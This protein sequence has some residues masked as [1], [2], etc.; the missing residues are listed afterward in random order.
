MSAAVP[1][2]RRRYD[3]ALIQ[4]CFA[5]PRSPLLFLA[6]ICMHNNCFVTYNHISRSRAL[7][8]M[9]PSQRHYVLIIPQFPQ[10]AVFSLLCVTSRYLFR[11]TPL[12]DQRRHQAVGSLATWRTMSKP[13]MAKWKELSVTSSLEAPPIR[14]NGC[15]L[16]ISIPNF[17]LEHKRSRV[18]TENNFRPIVLM[19]FGNTHYCTTEHKG[20][21]CDGEGIF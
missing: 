12:C 17:I 14:W 16:S 13:Q 18:A 7:I 8:S 11:F 21:A 19:Y 20:H 9:A 15:F 5:V 6:D 1:A 3:D 2:S 4:L 10:Y